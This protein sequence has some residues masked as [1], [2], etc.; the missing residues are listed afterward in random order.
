MVRARVES[1][2]VYFWYVLTIYAAGGI[3]A[4]TCIHVVLVEVYFGGKRTM[5]E[6]FSH[7]IIF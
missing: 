5:P 7:I 4:L 6:E 1:E 3:R 2:T